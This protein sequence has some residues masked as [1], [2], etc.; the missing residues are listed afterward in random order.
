MEVSA[1]SLVFAPCCTTIKTFRT[2]RLKTMDIYSTAK[3]PSAATAIGCTMAKIVPINKA[4]KI[5]P[6]PRKYG[7]VQYESK[8][9]L[10]RIGEVAMNM[11]S[12]ENLKAF[13]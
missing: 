9:A 6:M 11:R 3:I 13:T 5:W 4:L 8:S 12:L 2:V 7:F 10:E 1:K